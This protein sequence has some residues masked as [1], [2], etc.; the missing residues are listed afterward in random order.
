[1]KSFSADTKTEL[2]FCSNTGHCFLHD[3]NV[4][5]SVT[6]YV[7]LG[8]NESWMKIDPSEP[9]QVSYVVV[10]EHRSLLSQKSF[11]G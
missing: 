4:G 10:L 5:E 2:A 7:A 8:R 1:M 3:F 9:W 6:K 11:E